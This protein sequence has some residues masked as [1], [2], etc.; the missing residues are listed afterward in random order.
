MDTSVENKI[1]D[2]AFKVINEHTI[3]GT[4]MHLI[5]QECGMAQSNLHYHFKT[6]REL[7]IAVAKHM[8]DF[9]NDTRQAALDQA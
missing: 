6:K 3:S 1:L 2:A 7:L 4:R 8:Q 5:S 9:Y